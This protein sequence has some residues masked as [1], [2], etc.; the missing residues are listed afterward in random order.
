MQRKGMENFVLNE[1]VTGDVIGFKGFLRMTLEGFNEL[2]VRIKQHVQRSD[3]IM[4]DSITS[5][6][7]LVVTLRYIVTGRVIALW[8]KWFI[9]YVKMK[10]ERGEMG[11]EGRG[12]NMEREK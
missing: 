7:M 11:R 8:C 5:H 4:R 10:G 12:G 6:E 3:T 1:L 2:L 9:I